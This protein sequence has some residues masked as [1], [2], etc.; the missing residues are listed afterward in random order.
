MLKTSAYA[1]AHASAPLAPHTIERREP[2][3]HDVLID[4][5]YCGV[6]HSDL[7]QARDEWGGALFPMV[8]GHEI[9]GRVGRVGAEVT[10]LGVGDLVGVGC[11]VDSCRECEVC[12]RDLEQ[13]CEK[14]SAQTYNGTEMD[15]ETPTYGGYS[16]R[17]VVPEH[18]ALKIPAGLD[19]AGAA[20]LLCAGI[21][22]YSPLRQYGCKKGDRVAVV[23]LGGLGHMAVKLAASMGAEVTLLS[24]SPSKEADARRLGAHAFAVTK[25]DATFTRLANQ[26]DLIIDTVSAPHDYNKYLGT[27]RVGGTMV[28]VG[29]PPEPTPVGAMGLIWGNKRLAGSGIGGM[30]ETQEMLD[31]CAAHGIVSDIELIPIQQINQAYER[32]LAGDVRYR[33]VIDIASL[34]RP[35]A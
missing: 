22:T 2:G 21:T 16:T 35:A 29:V 9:V 26:F 10:K 12:R 5:L 30:A 24:T 1:A 14:G 4:I 23:G 6:C 11:I 3:P 31:Y 28:L 17:I 15:R 32:L 7:H 13:F 8:P 34:E 25:D 18:F 20:P 33:F 27:L 19:P